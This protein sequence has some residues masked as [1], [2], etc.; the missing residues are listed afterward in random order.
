MLLLIT[1]SPCL[2]SLLIE[3]ATALTQRIMF[4]LVTKVSGSGAPLLIPS[5]VTVQHDNMYI[6]MT[7]NKLDGMNCSAW[8]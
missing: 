4:E 8:S 3:F 6:Q 7:S 1:Y 5:V 2:L